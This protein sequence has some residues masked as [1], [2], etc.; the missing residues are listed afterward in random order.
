MMKEMAYWSIALDETDAELEAIKENRLRYAV[1]T[2]HSSL[3]RSH[4]SSE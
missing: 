1:A 4:Q 3:L 2:I